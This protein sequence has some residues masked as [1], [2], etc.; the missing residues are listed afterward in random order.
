MY[1]SSSL[2]GREQAIAAPLQAMVAQALSPDPVETAASFGRWWVDSHSTQLIL[3]CGSAAFLGVAAGLHRSFASCFSWVI[4]DDI[5]PLMAALEQ[6]GV[7]GQTVDCEFR[8]LDQSNQ[9]RWLRLCSLPPAGNAA[10][11]CGVLL[12]ITAVKHAALRERFSFE[13]TQFL[14]GS[15]SMDEAVTRVIQ[16]V[17]DTLGWAWGAYW[18]VGEEQMNVHTLACTHYWHRP[19]YALAAFTRESCSLQLQPGE[20]LV[21][22]VWSSGVASWVEQM[23]NDPGCVRRNSVR[24]SGLLSGYAFPVTFASADGQRHSPGVLEFFS[25]MSR[26]REAQLPALSAAIGALIAQTAQRLTQQEAFRRRSRIDDLTGLINRHYFCQLLDTACFE[27][28]KS[29]EVFGVLFID[30]DRFKPINDA[31]GHEV[32]NVVLREFAQRLLALLPEGCQAGRLGGDE[33]AI[34]SAAGM[35]VLQL[36]VVAEQVLQAARMPFMFAGS[37]LALSASVGVTVFPEH[38]WTGAELMRNADAA[39]Y[40]SKNNGRNA[41]SFFAAGP[42]AIDQMPPVTQPALVLHQL[43]N[44]E[45]LHRALVKDEFFL[46]YQPI[47]DSPGEKIVAVEALI[48]WRHPDGDIVAPD[49]FVPIAEQSRLIVPLGRWVL[50]QAC[51]D[52][53]ALHRAGFDGLQMHVNMA[54]S[55]FLGTDLQIEYICV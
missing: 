54:G 29:S 26:Q 21:G 53:S 19:E 30:L 17:C 41:K 24:E 35:S 49:F 5:L 32:G 8:L 42:A 16:L 11:E 43:N 51:T 3:S 23:G 2:L 37:E 36:S 20:G 55:E 18:A 7:P 44:E 9:L 40:R 14:I 15:H 45:E 31:F 38:G 39:M 46:E 25:T 28:T 1:S 48:R 34:L 10:Y 6:L 33:F 47:F 52:L 50:T 22:G 4:P 13:S 12:D 27:G